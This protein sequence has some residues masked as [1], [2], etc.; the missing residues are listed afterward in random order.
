[1]QIR[2]HSWYFPRIIVEK[3]NAQRNFKLTRQTMIL[4]KICL[5]QNQCWVAS[6]F[7]FLCHPIEYSPLGSSVHEI[8]QARILEWVATSSSRRSSPPMDQTLVSCISCI[9]RQILYHWATRELFSLESPN[10]QRMW[11]FK[12]HIGQESTHK[13]GDAG[14]SGSNPQSVRSPGEG[15]DNPSSFLAWKIPW[16]EELA[17]L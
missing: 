13:S 6:V 4:S 12:W 1:M 14:D 8:F 5:L 2:Y 17:W 3:S 10:Q 16:T 11:L 15:N 7:P 9:G